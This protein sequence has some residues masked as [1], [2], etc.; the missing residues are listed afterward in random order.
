MRIMKGAAVIESIED[1]LAE[2]PPKGGEDQWV[3]TYS[4]KEFA[5][6]WFTGGNA[7]TPPELTTVLESHA[8][9]KSIE[10]VD[11]EPEARIRFD[12]R[13][14]E[15]RNADMAI[16]ARLQAKPFAITI[17]AKAA[18]SFDQ[19]LPDTLMDAL[20]RYIPQH[21]GGGMERVRDLV[22]SLLS[23]AMKDLP[24]LRSVR[25]QLLTAVAGT[26]AWANKIGA[27]RCALIIHE[28]HSANTKSQDTAR[29]ATDLNSFMARLTGG[30]V[31]SI[32][33]NTLLGPF[34][35]RGKPLFDDPAQLYIGKIVRRV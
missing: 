33:K 29:N 5:R 28:F 17:E 1:W 3:N 11:G 16:R 19:L 21:R 26:L 2:A 10:L 7:S 6:A 20:E 35:V 25:Y 12:R 14:G 22:A 9:T 27:T 32:E 15:V 8:D 30:S 34:K 4:A 31:S 23:P 18:E 24:G 13:K